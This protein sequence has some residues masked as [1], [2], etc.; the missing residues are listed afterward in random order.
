[1]RRVRIRAVPAQVVRVVPGDMVRRAAPASMRARTSNAHLLHV[2]TAIVRVA[3]VLK[4]IDR[5]AACH[6]ARTPDHPA[7]ARKVIAPAAIVPAVISRAGNTAAP[8]ALRRTRVRTVRVR[9][10]RTTPRVVRVTKDCRAT[11]IEAVRSKH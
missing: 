8:A 10:D 7:M 11:R 5:R 9:I 1:M 3:I 6:A 2:R 4:A